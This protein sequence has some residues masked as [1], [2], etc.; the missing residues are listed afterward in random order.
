[1]RVLVIEDQAVLRRLLYA[2]LEEEGYAVDAAADG[3]EG[4]AKAQAWPY[5]AV[6]LDLML[7]KLDGW[8][9][10]DEL[11]RTHRTPVV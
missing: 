5:D 3:A 9:L 10:L 8:D 2:M 4:L 1:M 7:P 6:V 11:R